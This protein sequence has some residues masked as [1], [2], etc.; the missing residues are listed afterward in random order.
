MKRILIVLVIAA[1]AAG[2]SLGEW[3][4]RNYE[5]MANVEIARIQAEAQIQVAQA[6]AQAQLET[7]RLWVDVLPLLLLL[8]LASIVAGILIARRQAPPP[9]APQGPMIVHIHPPQL[10][11]GN[12]GEEPYFDGDQVILIEQQPPRRI[13]K[14]G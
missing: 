12:A 13:S 10:N 2:C 9:P 11:Q 1:A 6:Q 14:F 3:T 7:T 5:A 8:F 4:G